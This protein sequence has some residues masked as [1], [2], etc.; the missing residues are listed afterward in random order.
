M[1]TILYII[2]IYFCIFRQIDHVMNLFASRGKSKYA[3]RVH[4]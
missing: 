4:V 1:I 2:L 3:R